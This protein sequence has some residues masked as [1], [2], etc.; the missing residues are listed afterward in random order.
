MTF[1]G[2]LKH[3]GD[4]LIIFKSKR[5]E[6]DGIFFPKAQGQNIDGF[7]RM[8]VASNA[9]SPHEE[10]LG[11]KVQGEN[12]HGHIKMCKSCAPAE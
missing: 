10:C 8:P 4:L 12:T 3:R 1:K 5:S 7:Q 6:V 9:A 11:L 2:R